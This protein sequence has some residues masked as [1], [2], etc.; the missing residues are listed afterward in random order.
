MTFLTSKTKILVFNLGLLLIALLLIWISPSE[1]TLGRL[2]KLVYVHAAVVYAAFFAFMVAGVLGAIY[3][4]TSRPKL[5]LWLR[6]FQRTAFL[7]WG[8]YFLSSILLTYLAWGGVGWTEPRFQLA[9]RVFVMVSVVFLISLWGDWPKVTA[10]LNLTLFLTI[11]YLTSRVQRI[12][13]PSNP[14]GQSNS[15]IMKVYAVLILLIFISISLVTAYL[16]LPSQEKLTDT[17]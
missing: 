16:M 13:H 4:A 15:L 11:F 14:I 17:E 10:F 12:F 8:V 6:A 7:F 2:V 5:F 3:I 9:I 1:Q